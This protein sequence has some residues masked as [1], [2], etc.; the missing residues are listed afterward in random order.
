[1]SNLFPFAV[2]PAGAHIVVD[3]SGFVVANGDTSTSG[4]V[5][6]VGNKGRAMM[7]DA[8][9]RLILSALSPNLG[10]GGGGGGETNTA[11]NLGSGSGVFR[12]KSGV[13]LQ[14]RS[15]TVGSNMGINQSTNEL[16]LFYTALDGDGTANAIPKYTDPNTLGDS[17][18]TEVNSKIG[19]GVAGEPSGTLEIDGQM[20]T[21]VPAS[22]TSID[23]TTTVDLSSSN[24]IRCSVDG[25]GATVQF[26]NVANGGK[27][28]LIL[29]QNNGGS[30]TITTWPTTFKWRGGS[31]PTLSATSGSVDVVT[32]IYDGGEDIY[33][34]DVSKGFA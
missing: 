12:Q 26:T 5:Y 7:V 29:K 33:Y 34:G 15:L 31:A 8:S 19:V 2:G 23:G 1:M 28:T 17:V 24:V 18:I 32:F 10:G 14:F 16:E 11:A 30:G 9:G 20:N 25:A 22:T 4:V 3:A 21:P 13:Q 6:G 27:Y